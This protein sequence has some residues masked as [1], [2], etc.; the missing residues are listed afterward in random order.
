MHT[1][2]FVHAEFLETV[3]LN[4]G[5]GA[6]VLFPAPPDLAAPVHVLGCWQ[7]VCMR[8]A[9]RTCSPAV[10][11]TDPEKQQPLKCHCEFE[12]S[13]PRR[14]PKLLK[15]CTERKAQKMD[16]KALNFTFLCTLFV[17]F[18]FCNCAFIT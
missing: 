16:K 18:S 17:L 8:A 1:S 15:I 3:F 7:R 11:R 5:G 6:A 2:K 12:K 14:T 10:C 13:C 4:L 9:G